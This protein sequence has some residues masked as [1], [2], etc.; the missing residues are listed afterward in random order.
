MNKTR[1][2][3]DHSVYHSF[4]PLYDGKSDIRIVDAYVVGG[5]EGIFAFYKVDE[6]P[7]LIYLANGDDGNWWRI[8]NGF[9]FWYL[10]KIKRVL[11]QLVKD[12]QFDIDKYEEEH[13]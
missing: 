11:D 4:P 5:D 8:D 1:I 9:H 7:D 10:P 13:F 2:K 6:K 3:V 12:K